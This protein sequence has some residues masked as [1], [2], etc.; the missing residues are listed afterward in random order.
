MIQ[1]L[2]FGPDQKAQVTRIAIERAAKDLSK[3]WISENSE[4]LYRSIP[5]DSMKDTVKQL[6][7]TELGKRLETTV[8]RAVDESLRLLGEPYY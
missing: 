1:P 5:V 7:T 3:K 8:S 2:V 4:E 6:I